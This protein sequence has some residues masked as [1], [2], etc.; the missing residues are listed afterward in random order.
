MYMLVGFWQD[1]RQPREGRQGLTKAALSRKRKLF[2]WPTYGLADGMVGPIFKNV[3]WTVRSSKISSVS[4]L[5]TAQPLSASLL[6]L[7][8]RLKLFAD[9]GFRRRNADS[10]LVM[11][12]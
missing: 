6:T 2:T 3:D 8:R 4:G 1:I 5:H 10:V 12:Q 9:L 11:G 7:E